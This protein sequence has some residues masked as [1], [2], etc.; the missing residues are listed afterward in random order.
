M[1]QADPLILLIG[2]PAIPVALLLGKL[3]RWE[4]AL[5]RFMRKNINKIPFIRSIP[6]F[7]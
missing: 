5:L 3:I 6:P 7:R 2:L 4:D 1:E